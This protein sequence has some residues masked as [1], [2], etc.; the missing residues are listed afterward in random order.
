MSSE[1]I[2]NR[3]FDLNTCIAVIGFHVLAISAFFTFSW[4]ALYTFIGL[5]A[6]TLCLGVTLGFHR[7]LTHQSFQTPKWLKYIFAFLGCLALQGG[8]IRWVATHRLHHKNAD[9][10][11]DPHSS[12]EGFAWCH[13]RWNFYRQPEL[14]S[15]ETY[16]KYAPE[17][18]RDPVMRFMDKYFF[19]IFLAFS[20]AMF[21][22]VT[23]FSN[24]HLG[25]SVFVWGSILRIVYLW[26]VSWLVNSATH[27]WGYQTYTSRDE[28]RNN[29][30]VALLTFGEGWHNNHHVNPRSAQMGRAWYELDIT[31]KVIQILKQLGLAKKVNLLPLL[32]ISEPSHIKA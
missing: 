6:I 28:S 18:Y 13:W 3:H 21:S 27:Y 9:T 11:N 26:Q 19:G 2:Q 22:I 25:L 24:W 4:P 15:I 8:P 5:S 7:L 10:P 16:K 23:A 29:W 30:W 31:Y 14:E 32:E 20:F 1:T 17:L 12:I